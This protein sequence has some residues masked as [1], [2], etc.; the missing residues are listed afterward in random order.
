LVL[1]AAMMNQNLPFFNH[2]DLSRGC[3]RPTVAKAVRD[4]ID[5]VGARTADIEPGSPWENGNYESFNA[6][7][8]DSF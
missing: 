5:A 7:L 8:R 2:P 3:W 6:N 4:W 1:Q